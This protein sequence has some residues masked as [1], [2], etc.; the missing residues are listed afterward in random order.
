MKHKMTAYDFIRYKEEGRKFTYLTAYDYIT[1]TILDESKVE[2]VL[3]GDSL[4]P[5][6]HGAEG[7]VEVT[8]DEIIYH[9]KHVVKGC[10]NTHVIADMPFGSYQVSVEKAV[11]NACRIYKETGCDSIKLEGGRPY[12]EHVKAI[13]TAGVPVMGHIG[14]T[15]QNVKQ[16][17]GKVQGTDR[18]AALDLIEDAKALE[19]AGV[20]SMVVESVPAELGKALAE[21]TRVPIL[22]YGAGPDV[23]CQVMI[24]QTM[25][26]MYNTPVP[27]YVKVFAD[28][29]KAM[30]D[31]LNA[32]QEETESGEYPGTQY[33]Y[34][35]DL[36]L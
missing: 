24:T 20:F 15:Q 16:L 9:T 28:I 8:V 14:L 13:I 25:L 26:G 34:S 36:D 7:T 4:G 31:G 32:F 30:I 10:P 21:A 35:A 6:V 29:R 1:A 18:Q 11:E 17:E 12:L 2:V 5:V 3:V 23:D 22:G 33:S 27:K 19:E